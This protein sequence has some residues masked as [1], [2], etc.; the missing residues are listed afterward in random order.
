MEP[1][2][3]S[4]VAQVAGF[5]LALGG[6][7]PLGVG[8][9]DVRK[10]DTSV[11][12]IALR[13]PSAFVGDLEDT[14]GA[15]YFATFSSAIVPDEDLSTWAPPPEKAEGCS[16]Y[17]SGD[18][19]AVARGS[20]VI[21]RR[22]TCTF[23]E[24]AIY[25]QQAAA[26]GIIVVSDSE[27]ILLMH[28]NGTSTG[29]EERL[30]IFAI[31]VTKSLGDE[32]LSWNAKHDRTEAVVLAFSYYYTG[33]VNPSEVIVIFLA[34][35][36]VVAGA[37]F[38]T[39]DLRAGSPLAPRR[40]EVVEVS[41]EFA[42]I[43]CLAGSLLLVVLFFL[44]RYLIY[45]IIAVFC[46]GGATCIM[47]ITTTCLQY[48]LPVLRHRACAIPAVGTVTRADCVATVP[49]AVLIVGWLYFRNTHHGWFFQDLIGAGFLCTIQR[50]LRM[51]NI[52]VATVLLSAMFFFDIFWVFVSPLLFRQSVM[53]EVARGGGTGEAVPMLLRVPAVGDPLGRDRMLGFG[54]VALPG[55]LVSYLLRHDTQSKR[56]RLF[57]GYFAPAVL[58]Y[59]VGLTLTI[60]AL[61]IMSIGQPALLYLVPTTLGTTL[62]LGWRRG[63]LRALWD[64]TP[65]A[66]AG[67]PG[68]QHD[69]EGSARDIASVEVTS[70]VEDGV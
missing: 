58:G 70:A 49:T 60:M 43:W 37:Y 23:L 66:Y 1:H 30:P 41:K 16:P 15:G 10:P 35:A 55:L 6:A 2:R 21:V 29:E 50:T 20:V 46:I 45:V 53:V 18:G 27:E 7:L 25:A 8:A 67:A 36:L 28:G 17:G 47:H 63:E 5:L 57:A 26:R 32:F 9:T 4:V 62:V 24:K 22:G 68:H 19:A 3:G 40:D 52:K 39:A 44:M 31:S 59:F 56:K 33:L 38:S 11:A 54:D 42:I 12:L 69:P 51:P 61:L 65:V 48:L 64:G 14:M 34:T 13:A